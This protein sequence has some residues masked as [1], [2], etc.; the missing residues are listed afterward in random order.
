MEPPARSASVCIGSFDTH[1]AALFRAVART[2][3]DIKFGIM[4]TG[5]LAGPFC[6]DSITFCKEPSALAGRSRLHGKP[7]LEAVP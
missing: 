2:C 4:I 3:T 1:A 5:S 6:L 7:F